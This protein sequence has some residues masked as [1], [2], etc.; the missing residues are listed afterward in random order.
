MTWPWEKSVQ[1]RLLMI[2][3][4]LLSAA[5]VALNIAMT[6]YLARTQLEEA[7]NHLQ[8]QSLLAAR[9]LEDPLTVYSHELE[10]RDHDDHHDEH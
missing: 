6:G 5:L 8:I 2:F 1:A 9:T 4:G 3:V 7:A 10:E